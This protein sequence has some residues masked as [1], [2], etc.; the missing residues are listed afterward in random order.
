YSPANYVPQAIG[1]LAGRLLRLSP[2]E[3]YRLSGLVDLAV[4]IALVSTAALLVPE[5]APILAAIALAPELIRQAASQNPDAWIF[6]VLAVY[7]CLILRYAA[8]TSPLSRRQAAL[9]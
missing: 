5:A 7:V 9:L 1:L 6:G 2:L 3:S 4:F 8:T